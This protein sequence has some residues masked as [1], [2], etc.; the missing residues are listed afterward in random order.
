MTFTIRISAV[1]LLISLIAP[2]CA[3]QNV[4]GCSS[5]T[6]TV[7]DTMACAS[8][9][10]CYTCGARINFLMTPEGGSQTEY[11]ACFQVAV[12]EFPEVC[13][14]CNPVTCNPTLTNSPDDA[15][16]P[17]RSPNY[18][19]CG[20]DSCT[21]IVLDTMACLGDECYT[22]GER[23]NYLIGEGVSE[24]EACL[25]VGTDEF[26]N[27][28]GA[29]SEGLTY[30]PTE[31]IP[32]PDNSTLIWS[33]EFSVDG[34]PNP[35]KW[36]YDVGGGGWGNG[37]L[38]YYTDRLDNAFVSNGILNIRAVRENYGGRE[39]T[40]ARLIS[41]NRGDFK[42]GRFQFRARLRECTGRGSWSALWML[43]TD[44][45]YGG[46]PDSGE[47]DVMEHVGYDSGRVH[48]TVHTK[49]FN[50]LIGTQLGDS[51]IIPVED[52]HVYDIK[53]DEDKID[54]IIDGIKYHE[55]LNRNE[56]FEEWPFDERFH[57]IMNVA[58]G[59]SWGGLEGVD[60]SAFEGDGQIMEVDWV[61]VYS[62]SST[63]SPSMSRSNSPTT[64]G[65]SS[66]TI[67][68][69]NSPILCV[70]AGF[71]IDYGEI[72]LPCAFFDEYFSD[73][74]CLDPDVSSHCPSTCNSCTEYECVDSTASW[75]SP[76][77]AAKCADLSTLLNPGQ[78]LFYC[79]GIEDLR[80][81][82]PA[83]CGLCD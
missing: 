79:N 41:K 44:W 82:C 5:C 62:E 40:S 13:G 58:V 74:W 43:P 80:T 49:A 23:V 14:P 60:S 6:Q 32:Q 25:Q 29:C 8:W 54:F 2:A 66:P 7:L 64:S 68:P 3:G 71:P 48:G 18:Q 34:E 22:C 19:M 36:G 15:P 38:Q 33:D 20:V 4:C 63:V 1:S 42:Y 27:I 78:I 70:D 47:I 12:T 76:A 11:E 73:C 56:G 67:S 59:G 69:T 83:T 45:L 30:A 61:R 31:S 57:I 21:Q 81:T 65:T 26:P 24:I 55:F 16:S 39:Y 46:W 50:H 72:S 10:E 53:W 9:G 17:T 75:L 77:G 35:E 37:E 52:W 51:I 28:C